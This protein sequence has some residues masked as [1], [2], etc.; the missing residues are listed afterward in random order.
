MSFFKQRCPVPGCKR[1]HKTEHAM[2][3][4][5]WQ[6]VSP[7]TQTEVYRTHNAWQSGSGA[8]RAYYAARKKA[9]EEAK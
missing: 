7:D 6:R 9:I 3:S 8:F 5:H 2:C 4:L 1:H